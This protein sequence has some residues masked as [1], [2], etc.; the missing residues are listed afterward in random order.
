MAFA[1]GRMRISRPT[2]FE[3][4]RLRKRLIIARRIHKILKDRLV[5]LTQ[6]FLNTLKRSIDERRKAHELLKLGYESLSMC[7][8]TMPITAIDSSASLLSKKPMVKIYTRSIAGVRAPFTELIHEYQ[9]ME[10]KGTE[11]PPALMEAHKYLSQS[12]D[13]LVR[14]A[15]LEKVLVLLGREMERTKRRVNMLEHVIIPRIEAT[16]RYLRMKFEEREREE[17]GRLK[18]VKT[19]LA[20]RRG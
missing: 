19:V 8:M 11:A 13:H 1:A 20:Q 4:I 5:V 14:L 3:L 7:R 2:K 15:E 10:I 12:L 6:E 18:H 16:I 9:D 17:K